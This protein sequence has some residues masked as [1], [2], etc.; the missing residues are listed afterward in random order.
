MDSPCSDSDDTGVGQTRATQ[1]PNNAPKAVEKKA[2]PESSTSVSNLS[3]SPS[4]VLEKPQWVQ[5]V[6]RQESEDNREQ[7][8]KQFVS[9]HAGDRHFLAF[10]P[11]NSSVTDKFSNMR[12]GYCRFCKGSG[13]EHCSNLGTCPTC[14][15]SGCDD[16]RCEYCGDQ[17]C[18]QCSPGWTFAG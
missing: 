6:D 14:G 8:W 12:S 1:N 17:G 11:W 7:P 15:G 13:C 10:Q 3:T 4:Q 2:E 18:E 5:N 16:C 9:G